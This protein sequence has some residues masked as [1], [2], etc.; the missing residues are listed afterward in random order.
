[1]VKINKTKQKKEIWVWQLR[2]LFLLSNQIAKL[3]EL[4][5]IKQ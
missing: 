1:M 5:E 3:Q 4:E 2:G